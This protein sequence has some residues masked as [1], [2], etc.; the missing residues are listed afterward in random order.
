MREFDRF[1]TIMTTCPVPNTANTTRAPVRLDHMKF[2]VSVTGDVCGPL[3]QV[4]DGL[5]VIAFFDLGLAPPEQVNLVAANNT[6]YLVGGV[7]LTQ[8]QTVNIWYS[9]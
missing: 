3:N 6:I 8:V 2:T 4:A 7:D 5:V 1:G 9:Y